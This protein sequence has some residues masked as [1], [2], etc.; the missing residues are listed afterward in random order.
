MKTASA[1]LVVALLFVICSKTRGDVSLTVRPE[2]FEIVAGS[3]KVVFAKDEVGRFVLTTH[4]HSGNS[5]QPLFDGG[6]PLL[7]GPDFNVH[8]QTF[9][10][11]E[12]TPQR[13][14]VS[15]TG[16]HERHKYKCQV[17]VEAKADSELLRFRVTC[18]LTVSYTHLT[19]PTS[20]LV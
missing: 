6:M 18:P 16:V 17:L 20:D 14:A 10:V 12:D 8:P 19:L 15:L 1:C 2:R 3:Q 4:V 9:R 11:V 5:W 7:Q 13:V